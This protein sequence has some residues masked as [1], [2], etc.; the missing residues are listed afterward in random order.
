MNTIHPF[1]TKTQ[2]SH[3]PLW[4]IGCAFESEESTPPQFPI[5]QVE[6]SG[7]NQFTI[8]YTNK[9]LKVA[10]KNGNLWILGQ[11]WSVTIPTRLKRVEDIREILEKAF[12]EMSERSVFSRGVLQTGTDILA[13]AQGISEITFLVN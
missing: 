3:S 13:F 2:A 4:E 8:T 1:T 11:P 5:P 12:D 7:F 10:M 6:V 9:V